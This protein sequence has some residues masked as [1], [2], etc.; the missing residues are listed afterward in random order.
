MKL[1][2]NKRIQFG[3]TLSSS[4][5]LT[6]SVSLYFIYKTG[7]IRI[8]IVLPSPKYYIYNTTISLIL[9]ILVEAIRCIFQ[10]YLS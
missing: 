8:N 1:H 9:I 2:Q 10:W 4:L 6:S 7:Y 5:L 3:C